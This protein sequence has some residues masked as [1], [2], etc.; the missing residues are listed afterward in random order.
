[1]ARRLAPD[2]E[3]GLGFTLKWNMGWMHDTLD[4]VEREPVHRRFHHDELTFSL[5]YAWDENF[6]LPLSHDEVVHGKRSLLAKMPG[7][8]WQQL[9]NL[10]ALYAFSGLTPASSCSSWA[11]SW[12]SGASGRGAVA[13]RPPRRPGPGRR[14]RAVRDLNARL[15]GAARAL[16]GG[17]PARGLRLARRRRPRRERDR[18]LPLRG[19]SRDRRS[20]APSTS[21]RSCG[22]A[23]VC[24]CPGAAAWAEVLNTDSRFYAGSDVGNGLCILRR[25]GCSDARPA[26][27]CARHLAAARGPLARARAR[28]ARPPRAARASARAVERRSLPAARANLA[29]DRRRLPTIPLLSRRS[30]AITTP[31]SPRVRGVALWAAASTTTARRSAGSCRRRT[32]PWRSSASRCRVSVGPSIPTAAARSCWER[33]ADALRFVSTSHIGIEPPAAE[34]HDPTPG[35]P[36]SRQ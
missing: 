18:L 35:E 25:T 28:T 30:N 4:Y 2:V 13:R 3:G 24:R 20:S 17:L 27:L 22:R 14:A 5:V 32:N 36:T 16:G 10:R 29:A 9:A 21:P 19:R 23:G 8:R 1:M 33:H 31:S 12:R 11:A 34:S 15:P 26:G 6:V 7:D